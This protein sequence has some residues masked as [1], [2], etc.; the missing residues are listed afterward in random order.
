MNPDPPD[1]GEYR[2]TAALGCGL[3]ALAYVAGM[4]LIGGLALVVRWLFQ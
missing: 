2:G 1:D 3:V 4:A